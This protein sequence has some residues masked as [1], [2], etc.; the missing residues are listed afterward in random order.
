[1][2]EEET[3]DIREI[4]FSSFPALLGTI[5]AMKRKSLELTQEDMADTLGITISSWSRIERGETALNIEQ[6]LLASKKLKIKTSELIREA[7]CQEKI[8]KEKGVKIVMERKEYSSLAKIA[9]AGVVL[10]PLGIVGASLYQLIKP[11]VQITHVS[12]RKEDE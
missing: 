11:S 8:L 12:S 5:M 9:A 3:R 1:M 6:L 2:R 10:G 7:E 4:A